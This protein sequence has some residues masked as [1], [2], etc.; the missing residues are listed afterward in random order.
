MEE[1]RDDGKS[2]THEGFPGFQEQGTRGCAWFTIS[3]LGGDGECEGD[4]L[5]ASTFLEK[6]L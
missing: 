4:S 5:L 3:K 6:A 2:W 1:A